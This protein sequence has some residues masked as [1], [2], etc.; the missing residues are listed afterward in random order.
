M[1]SERV[2]IEIQIDNIIQQ[3]R[4]LTDEAIAIL[5]EDGLLSSKYINEL[6]FRVQEYLIR[7]SRTL[8]K[9]LHHKNFGKL[10]RPVKRP[11]KLDLTLISQHLAPKR[12]KT[13]HLHTPE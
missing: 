1:D 12:I 6:A 5:Y 7:K 4:T 2:L 13:D 8:K 3:L 11:Q 10:K 9:K